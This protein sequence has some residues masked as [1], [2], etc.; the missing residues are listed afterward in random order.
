MKYSSC[1]YTKLHWL[2]NWES[3]NIILE[4]YDFG[5][6]WDEVRM[7]GETSQCKRAIMGSFLDAHSM[8]SHGMGPR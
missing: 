2:Y 1:L 3:T 5:V 4:L 8:K 6:G 7:A